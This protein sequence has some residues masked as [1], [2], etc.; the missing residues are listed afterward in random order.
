MIIGRVNANLEAR[1]DL[2]IE[3]G[4]GQIHSFDGA[5]DTGFTGWM[6]L[7]PA[8]VLNLGL[9]WLHYRDIQ[10]GNGSVERANVYSAT[11]IWDSQPRK[12]DVYAIDSDP[13]V[14]MKMLAG[15][16]LRMR[17]VDGGQVWIDVIP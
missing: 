7:P 15:Y 5:I 16:E 14:G 12:V 10:L 13:L 9:A 1:I 8:L 2:F 17:V 4:N 11:V 3:H 6:C